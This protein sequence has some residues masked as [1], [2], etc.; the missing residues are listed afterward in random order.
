M[1]TLNITLPRYLVYLTLQ[2]HFAYRTLPYTYLKVPYLTHR[3]TGTKVP[4][5]TWYLGSLPEPA[6]PATATIEG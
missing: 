5:R 4:K 6:A 2:Y 1:A 3:K